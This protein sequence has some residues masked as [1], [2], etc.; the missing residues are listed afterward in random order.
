MISTGTGNTNDEKPEYK[1][2]RIMQTN[3]AC[4]IGSK[5]LTPQVKYLYFAFVLLFLYSMRTKMSA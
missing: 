4:T 5:Y 1:V 2:K 3:A